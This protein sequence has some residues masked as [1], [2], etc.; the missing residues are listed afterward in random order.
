MNSGGLDV[1]VLEWARAEQNRLVALRREFHAW[2][3][4]A[5]QEEKTAARIEA[6]LD[7]IGLAHRRVAGT[8]VIALLPGP[9]DAPW[10]ALRA[11]IDPLPIREAHDYPH[12]SKNPGVMHACG[13]D[14]HMA[15][16]LTAA[17]ILAEHRDRLAVGVKFIFQPAEETVGGGI[18]LS[19]LPDMAEVANFAALHLWPTLPAGTISVQ[20]GPRMASADTFEIEITG[21]SAHGSMPHVGVDALYAAAQVVTALQAVVS[22]RTNPLEP[23]VVSVGTFQ[24]GTAANIIAPTAKL[25]GTMRTFNDDVRREIPQRIEEIVSSVAAAFGAKG[26]FRLI[27]G[28]PPVVNDAASAAVAAASAAEAVGPYHVVEAPPTPGAEDFA[29]F[30]ARAPGVMAW[31]GCG[32]A[33]KGITFPIHHECYDLDEDALV[34]GA[35]F[36]AAYALN[37]GELARE[38]RK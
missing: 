28:T 33:A 14:G 21:R 22:R 4:V 8:G 13:H 12:A 36:M 17:K 2:P 32:N 7:R 37:I 31:I 20:P 10:I 11:D 29:H 35:A 16:L 15:I 34:Y 6:E 38:K 19:A 18:V 26:A 30:L 9:A 23:A 3:E 27:P 1:S 24:S 25:S 5:W